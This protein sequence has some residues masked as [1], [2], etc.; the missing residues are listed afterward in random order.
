[1]SLFL[2]AVIC[3]SKEDFLGF[4]EEDVRQ[5][6]KKTSDLL[7]L[8]KSSADAVASS[9]EE[10]S[11]RLRQRVNKTTAKPFLQLVKPR[12]GRRSFLTSTPLT[13]SKR[14]DQKPSPI[15]PQGQ[16][17]HKPMKGS[18]KVRLLGKGFLLKKREKKVAQL[19]ERQL[20][21]KQ[22]VAVAKS[23]QVAPRV[24]L[25]T[26]GKSVKEAIIKKR[27]RFLKKG[28]TG[29]RRKNNEVKYHLVEKRHEKVKSE[30]AEVPP[31][32]TLCVSL[33]RH[34]AVRIRKGVLGL[35]RKARKCSTRLHK[36]SENE[37]DAEDWTKSFHLPSESSHSQR[38]ITANKRFLDNTSSEGVS[39]PK[40]RRLRNT[41][42]VEK[43]DLSDSQH[44]LP[45]KDV[46]ENPIL[47]PPTLPVSSPSLPG[48]S[49]VVELV[50][51]QA[52]KIPMF[53]APLICDSKRMRKPSQKLIMELSEDFS[54]KKSKKF[55]DG[56]SPNA[57]HSSETDP[58][59][60]TWPLRKSAKLTVMDSSSQRHRHSVQR[61]K[62][63]LNQSLER[64]ADVSG[65]EIKQERKANLSLPIMSTTGAVLS[66][67][68][69]QLGRSL[70]EVTGF[71][72]NR[73][74]KCCCICDGTYRLSHHIGCRS[75]CC[76]SCSRFF[77]SKAEQS[78]KG[79]LE[80]EC[81]GEGE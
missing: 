20:K 47:I 65:N 32:K 75:L 26:V 69:N 22:A 21:E 31:K 19:K 18:I 73:N 3:F 48:G 56:T 80:L 27:G 76:R 7:T 15:S 64:K 62:R 4:T 61:A 81:L 51:D 14:Q 49:S 71:K 79:A 13:S 50:S 17:S 40:K 63:Y 30:V 46:I 42:K 72:K 6:I 70:S 52:K 25:K 12:F 44:E 23:S 5:V 28:K 16:S 53:D 34:R 2:Q 58:G 77:K 24:Q 10:I 9:V 54:S 60:F 33:S 11:G 35:K 57:E 8:V 78:L 29:R 59:E 39:A 74:K 37:E 43:I 45:C 66:Q 38:K 41:V 1:M 68:N 36:D 55:S 67:K